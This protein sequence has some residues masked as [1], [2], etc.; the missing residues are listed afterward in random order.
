MGSSKQI[1][2]STMTMQTIQHG[3]TTHNQIMHSAFCTTV[4]LSHVGLYWPQSCG[5]KP[6]HMRHIILGQ[7]MGGGGSALGCLG[8]TQR[9]AEMEVSECINWLLHRATFFW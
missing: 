6:R 3:Q 4:W 7:K 5:K 1:K 9:L 2:W 8:Y